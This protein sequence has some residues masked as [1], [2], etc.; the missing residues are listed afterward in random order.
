LTTLGNTW[1]HTHD[2][3][4]ALITQYERDAAYD[5]VGQG[6]LAV[7]VRRGVSP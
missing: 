4:L 3:V 1:P 2:E 6:P 7:F 5:R